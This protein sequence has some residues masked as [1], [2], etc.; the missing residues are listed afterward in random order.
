MGTNV[1]LVCVCFFFFF[2]TWLFYVSSWKMNNNF[3]VVSLTIFGCVQSRTDGLRSSSLHHL[4]TLFSLAWSARR[5]RRSQGA[6]ASSFCLLHHNNS[7]WSFLLVSFLS[8][9]LEQTTSSY[10]FF[11]LL[12]SSLFWRFST[13]RKMWRSAGYNKSS[14]GLRHSFYFTFSSVSFLLIARFPPISKSLFYY[15][16]V[17]SRKISG[18]IYRESGSSSSSQIVYQSL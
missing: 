16:S 7:V 13:T 8:Y 15:I 12:L 18:R 11:L 10:L 14:A 1:A 6:I 17:L 9:S 3:Q 2:S 4:I 5:R